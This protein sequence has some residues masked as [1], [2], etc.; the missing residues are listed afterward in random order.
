MKFAGEER[1]IRD[2]TLIVT[3]LPYGGTQIGHSLPFVRIEF[4]QLPR[5]IILIGEM[6]ELFRKT[7]DESI[8]HMYWDEENS[9]PKAGLPD[10]SLLQ[11]GESIKFS[12]DLH[13][14]LS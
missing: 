12:L 3:K 10:I 1:L 6:I 5:F 14:A 11:D 8:G 13:E 4:G 9:C 7:L 2:L